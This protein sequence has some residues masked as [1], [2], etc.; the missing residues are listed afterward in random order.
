[1][2][3]EGYVKIYEGGTGGSDEKTI[4]ISYK[5][6]T[7]NI[8]VHPSYTDEYVRNLMTRIFV[9]LWRPENPDIEKIEFIWCLVG[10]IVDKHLAGKELGIKRG[11]KQFVAGAKVYCF[12]SMWGDGYE[13]IMVIGKPRKR[14]K[15]IRVI[16]ESKYIKNWRL[17]KVYDPFVISEMVNNYGWSNLDEDKRTIELMLEWLPKRTVEELP[18]TEEEIKGKRPEEN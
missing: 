13:K 11:T 14:Q 6:S 1:M 12:P 17:Q 5:G 16:M 15:L 8:P 3:D 9:T 4:T 7:M 10:N 18:L 2:T